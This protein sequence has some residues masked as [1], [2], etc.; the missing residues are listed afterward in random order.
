[1]N[2]W[3]SFQRYV[4]DLLSYRLYLRFVCLIGGFILFL[5]I[6]EVYFHQFDFQNEPHIKK[7]CLDGPID[8][9]ITWVNGSDPLLQNKLRDFKRKLRIE[10][11]EKC[12]FILCL[13]SHI[14]ATRDLKSGKVKSLATVTGKFVNS[15]DSKTWM[16][17][18]W[19]NPTAAST[20]SNII[21]NDTEVSMSQ[22]YWTI[23]YVV[24]VGEITLTLDRITKWFGKNVNHIWFYGNAA[25]VQF[26]SGRET[27]NILQN[28]NSRIMKVSEGIKL[29]ITKVFLM[30]ELPEILY[31]SDLATSRY[32]DKE[33]LRYC[34]RSLE[35]HAPW[36]RYIYIVTNGQIPYWL[37]LE[38]K[39]IRL[40]THEDIFIYKSHLPTFSSPSIETHVHRIPGLSEKFLY[41]NDDLLIGQDIWPEDFI[42]PVTGQKIYLSWPVPDCSGTCPWVWVG[43]GACDAP[44]NNTDCSFD[45]G[46]CLPHSQNLYYGPINQTTH[47]SVPIENF[48]KLSTNQSEN[49]RKFSKFKLKTRG[50]TLNREKQIKGIPSYLEH[51]GYHPEMEE[52]RQT[53]DTYAESLL[54]VNKLFNRHYKYML[55]KVPAHMPHLID[56]NTMEN[57]QNKFQEE[58]VKTSSHR[59]R[60]ADDMQ[61][62]FTY[63]YYLISESLTVSKSEIFDRFDTDQSGTWSDREIRTILAH[64]YS[65][66][67][68]KGS[69]LHLENNLIKCAN[70]E[71]KLIQ[72]PQYERYLDSQLPLITKDLVMRCDKIMEPLLERFGTKPKYKYTILKSA[73]VEAATGFHMIDSNITT[74]LNTLDTIRGNSK[75]F[76]CINDNLDP[77]LLEDNE[78][79]KAVLLDFYHSLFPHPS[80]FE[81]D[82]EF[83]NRFL[84]YDDLLAWQLQRKLI[85]NF[86]TILMVLILLMISLFCFKP[87]LG[88]LNKVLRKYILLRH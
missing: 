69:V 57:L 82:L 75:K 86:L 16:I 73:E 35:Q 18:Y 20:I 17:M 61:M 74:L 46:D 44:C 5:H 71:D 7:Y 21:V 84:Y 70:E 2:R 36:I 38:N 40:V 63:Y 11:A 53:L 32:D 65:L 12:P 41:L 85:L 6:W 83:R 56:R 87:E 58:F 55:R 45:G 10:F 23:V 59:F 15:T 60:S 72:Q 78:L 4:Y 22:S 19:E 13:P 49:R 81:L 79:A 52:L 64:L 29:N 1:M 27:R 66:P 48:H 28:A 43:D 88:L 26:F 76:I 39:R 50:R 25:V 67:L 24:P 68:T 33:E 30:L 31:S 51:Y 37:N 14:T 8:A 77:N 34:L 47:E 80:E 3:K 54:Y 9:V 42:S 62:S